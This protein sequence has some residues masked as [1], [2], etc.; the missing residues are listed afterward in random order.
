MSIIR[1][2]PRDSKE[3]SLSDATEVLSRVL[4]DFLLISIMIG[5]HCKGNGGQNSVRL[6][7]GK[8]IFP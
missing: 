3:L 4:F 5:R 8:K 1:N 7:Q 6:M 2:V